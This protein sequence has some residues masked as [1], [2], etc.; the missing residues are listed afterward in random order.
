MSVVE[1]PSDIPAPAHWW[2]PDHDSTAGDEVADFAVAAGMSPDP[3]QR[4]AYRIM[5]AERK[6]AGEWRPACKEFGCVATRQNLKSYTLEGSALA[7][8]FYFNEGAIWTSHRMRTTG[9]AMAHIL[10][11]V[12]NY[13]HLRRQVKEISEENG[14]EYIETLA[15]A[16][17]EFMAR[18][19]H[20]GRGFTGPKVNYDEAAFGLTPAMTAALAPIKLTFPK[21]AQTRYFSSAGIATS[22]VLRAIRDR[23]RR[24]GDPTLGYLEYADIEPP[25]CELGDDCPHTVDTQG[26]CLDDPARQLRANPV[27]IRLGR[28]ETLEALR[29]LRLE[30]AAKPEMFARECLGWWDDP[31]VE[32]LF[33]AG[34]W[35]AAKDEDEES[36]IAGTPTLAVAV[37]RDRTR[38]A[39]GAAGL[40][41]D[42][43]VHLEPLEVHRLSAA[44]G[45]DE[46]GIARP[47]A[48][49]GTD[50]L[51]AELKRLQ[52]VHGGVVV[53]AG[54]GPGAD[55]IKPLEAAGV[56]IE[57]AGE[58]DVKTALANLIDNVEQGKAVHLGDSDL[59]AA[60]QNSRRRHVGDRFALDRKGDVCALEA[61]MLAAWGIDNADA[62]AQV[63]V[64]GFGD[65]DMCD[66]CGKNPH[67][68]PEGEHDYLCVDC[69]ETKE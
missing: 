25:S 20:G 35:A 63:T 61:V 21:T 17:L 36:S 27:Q 28:A 55:L 23:G 14:N 8:T 59:D 58:D 13:D 6:V 57:V 37:S 42:G 39:I 24:G 19:E 29:G 51:V 54:R 60:V 69:R 4:F 53:V 62:V 2:V 64:Y 66:H 45:R 50:G 10:E 5:Y 7:D 43:R 34:S 9:R 22:V 41:L 11:T 68:D 46:E 12:T 65:L 1:L 52:D 18:T 48:E 67:D 44:W 56:Q 49:P 32:Q 3:V 31:L 26:C 15:G 16:R 38:A 47:D 30:M 40:N 33:A